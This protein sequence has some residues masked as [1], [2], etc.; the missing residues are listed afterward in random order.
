MIRIPP[1][2]F[3]AGETFHLTKMIINLNEKASR[4]IWPGLTLVLLALA[5]LVGW[6][7][8]D[9]LGQKA[10]K[11]IRQENDSAMS[12]FYIHLTD[13]LNKIQ[14]A[15]KAMSGSPYVIPALQNPSKINLLRV[16]TAWTVTML[17]WGPP[18]AT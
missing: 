12:A 4:F 1:H 14:G 7:I 15:V 3:T 16:N 10:L 17:H 8:S 18:S 6:L 13:E 9:Y 11:E 5:T 2:L